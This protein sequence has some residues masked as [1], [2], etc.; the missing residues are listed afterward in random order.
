M[1]AAAFLA[2]W[3]TGWTVGCAVLAVA[4]IDD[5][6]LGTIAFAIPFWVAWLFV[7]AMLVGAVTR[8]QDLDVDD[9]GLLYF[10]RAVVR[11]SSRWI[12]RE[13]F[14]GFNVNQRGTHLAD[15]NAPRP[16][17]LEIR[18]AGKP[19]FIF[20]GLPEPE[21]QWLAWQL[22]QLVGSPTA[23]EASVNDAASETTADKKVVEQDASGPRPLRLALAESALPPPSDCTWERIA[24][25][26]AIAFLQRGRWSWSG[27]LGLL[28]VAAFWNGIV[29][30][31]VMLLFGL[32]P[33][34]PQGGE[35]W[36]LFV[37]LIP[38][39]L[40]GL[41][42]LVGL[43]LAILEP[44]RRTTWRFDNDQVVYRLTW[45][46]LGLRRTYPVVSLAGIELTQRANGS[47][48]ASGGKQL[49][50]AASGAQWSDE[51]SQ[52]GLSLVRPPNAEL[53]E[54]R[55][56]SEGE[57]RW[58]ADTVLRERPQWFR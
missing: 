55:P 58:M 52:F 5:P 39:E 32:M 45:L 49:Q 9:K 10:D 51:V 41:L 29:S 30:V 27:V 2:L 25:F 17:G 34:G 31:F 56:L 4:V 37:F 53:C 28:F 7:G 3:Q 11:L 8:R 14:R 43:L 20:G 33:G 12:P 50:V 54:I 13:E 42:L 6:K 48:P 36:F 22:S 21:L 44:L 47:K 57:A 19:L 18:S 23:D 15:S 38:F 35:W 40:I 46:G 16:V 24:D 26:S 1:G